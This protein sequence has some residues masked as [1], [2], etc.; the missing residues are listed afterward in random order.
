MKRLIVL[1]FVGCCMLLVACN[2]D[3]RTYD[4]YIPTPIEGWERN[5]TL[6]FSIPP[7]QRGTYLMN[8]GI[9]TTLSFPYQD[10]SMI[11]EQGIYPKGKTRKDTIRCQL[12]G[13]EGKPMG[14]SGISS[15]DQIFYIRTLELNNNDSLHVTLYH[16]M[17]RE[18]L[19]G[20]SAIGLQLIAE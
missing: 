20:I 7:Q 14:Q 11:M 8:M 16:C 4:Y 17:R 13:E 2:E 15:N 1:A 10:I 12:I 18:S 19:P 5:D 9:R 6:H 3:K